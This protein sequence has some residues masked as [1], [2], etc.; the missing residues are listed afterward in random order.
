MPKVI[1]I[2]CP[3]CGAMARAILPP[4][5]LIVL[6][7]CPSCNE[8]V[9]LLANVPLPVDKSIIIH[10]SPE[11]R[12]EHI[13]SVLNAFIEQRVA[14]LVEQIENDPHRLADSDIPSAHFD[15]EWDDN[16]G[17]SFSTISQE[18]MRKFVE[19]ELPRIDDS[20]YF[21]TIFH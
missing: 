16:Q 14:T 12:Y 19:E 11:E 8:F 21:N 9:L 1:D 7:P 3:H 4:E 17:E 18:E 13:L 15:T 10:G 5:G 2:K 20:A 6:G